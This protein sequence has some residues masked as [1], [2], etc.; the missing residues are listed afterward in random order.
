MT[1]SNQT[2]SVSPAALWRVSQR[3]ALQALGIPL[4][5][6]RQQGAESAAQYLYRVGPLWLQYHQPLPVC[7]PQW[8]V[9]VCYYL[10]SQPVQVSTLP[11]DPRYLFS[12]ADWHGLQP[13][14]VQKRELWRLLSQQ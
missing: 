6:A 7:K 8:L 1:D 10:D 13:S 3:E 9:D 5:Q 12:L 14:I 4:W 11:Q 2:Q